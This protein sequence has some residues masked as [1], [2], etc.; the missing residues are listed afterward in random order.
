M[1]RWSLREIT[2]TQNASRLPSSVASLEQSAGDS[3]FVVQ[4][5]CIILGIIL[6]LVLDEPPQER[7]CHAN[8]A[9]ANGTNCLSSACRAT[10]DPSPRWPIHTACSCTAYANH[11]SVDATA[12]STCSEPLGQRSAASMRLRRSLLGQSRVR[13]TQAESRQ[14]CSILGKDRHRCTRDLSILLLHMWSLN[15]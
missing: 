5:H 2:V 4:F 10:N 6:A 3:E 14:S 13:R 9:H 11:A 15:R 7:H 8:R 1:S 12:C